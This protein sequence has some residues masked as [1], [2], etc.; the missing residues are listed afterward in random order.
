MP[1]TSGPE[2]AASFRLLYPN[3]PVVFMSGYNEDELLRYGIAR[4]KEVLLNKPL[5]FELLIAKIRELLDQNASA[6]V[7]T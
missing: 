3:I 5:D 2:L 6:S 4:S 7:T 1:E